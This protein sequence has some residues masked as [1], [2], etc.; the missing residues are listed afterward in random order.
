MAS[1]IPMSSFVGISSNFFLYIYRSSFH[2]KNTNWLRYFFKDLLYSQSVGIRQK[3]LPKFVFRNQ[4]H[5]FLCAVRI[6]L[7]EDIIQQQSGLFILF[8]FQEAILSEL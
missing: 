1:L 3:D 2:I 7:I 6:E 5:Q 4:L 8:T